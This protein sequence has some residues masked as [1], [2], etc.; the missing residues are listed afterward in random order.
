MPAFYDEN[1][2]FSY[3]FNEINKDLHIMDTI[4]VTDRDTYEEEQIIQYQI[5]SQEVI[6]FRSKEVW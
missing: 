3:S 5:I 2:G 4:F 6:G 1:F